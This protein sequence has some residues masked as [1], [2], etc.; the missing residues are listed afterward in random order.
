MDQTHTTPFCYLCR[1]IM[2]KSAHNGTTFNENSYICTDEGLN[3]S[4]GCEEHH[5]FVQLE[6]L[7]NSTKVIRTKLESCPPMMSIVLAL[8]VP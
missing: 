4:V 2:K 6:N 1:A 7:E 3:P 8:R 5:S